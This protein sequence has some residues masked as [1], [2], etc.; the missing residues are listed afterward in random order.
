[1][2]LEIPNRSE[3]KMQ[4]SN[5]VITHTRWACHR[6]PCACSVAGYGAG[7]RLPRALKLL[8][9]GAADGAARSFGRARH[10]LPSAAI[11]LPTARRVAS[12]E[13]GRRRGAPPLMNLRFV[14]IY[15]LFLVFCYLQFFSGGLFKF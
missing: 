9:G 7:A 12:A 14:L 8:C 5:L 10:R 15:L 4:G 11:G 3:L 6:P 1:L 13:Q 2:N